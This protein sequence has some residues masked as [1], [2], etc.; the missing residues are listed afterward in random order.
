MGKQSSGQKHTI[1]PD[2]ISRPEGLPA[3]AWDS[4]QER[5]EEKFSALQR[6]VERAGHARSSYNHKEHEVRLGAWAK[7]QR[8][9]RHALSPDRISRLE[10]L[11]GW[12]WDFK[13]F[14]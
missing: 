4:A 3:W 8:D 13:G 5:W 9:Q 6:F 10:S 14:R 11:P 7:Y 12:V 2:R 1:R